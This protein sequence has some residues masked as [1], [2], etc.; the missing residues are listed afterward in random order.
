MSR[1]KLNVKKLAKVKKRYGLIGVIFVIV[2][3]L[4]GSYVEDYLSSR[5]AASLQVFETN[6]IELEPVILKRVVDGDTLVVTN[7]NREEV[8]VRLI[9]MDTPES[10]H[11]DQEKNTEAGELASQY[12]KSVLTVGQ[13][14][15]LEYD[16]QKTD[17]YHRVLAYV[18]LTDDVNPDDIATNMLNAK[19][20]AVGYAVAKEFKPNVKY[21]SLLKQ[22]ES[23]AN[24]E[25]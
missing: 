13:T 23:A 1:Q 8:R 15:Y 4:A 24:N 3:T 16:V 20:V 12:T 14:L 7:A 6:G 25:R 5:S 2:A 18:W 11:P 22:L 9:G 19:L 10:V 17:R 21:S